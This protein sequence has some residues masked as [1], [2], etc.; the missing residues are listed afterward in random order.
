MNNSV[1]RIVDIPEEML[2]AI[3]RKL[4]NIDILYS[5][6]GV[7]QKLDKVA[8][9]INFTRTIDLTMSSSDEAE[10][11]GTNTILD[12]FCM[13]I[14]PRIYQNIEYL[15]IQGCFSQRV[16]HASIYPN[17]RKLTLINLEL[18]MA[19]RMFN[20]KSPFIQIFKRQISDLVVTINNKISNKPKKK[21]AIGVYFNIFGLIENL[22]YLDFN[23]NNNYPFPR[24]LLSSL[25]STTCFLPKIAHLCIKMHNFNDCRWLLD[26]RL[27]QLHTCIVDVDYI[28]KSS[29]IINNTNTRLKLKSF[30]LYVR[31]PTVE[32]DNQVVPLLRRMVR[33]ETLT[34]SLS[35]VRRASFLDGTYLA[36]SIINHMSRL[37]TFVFDIVTRGTM[38]NAEIQPSADDIRRTFAQIGIHVDCYME[39]DS[40]GISR[41]HVYSLPFTMTHI[42]IIT[43][44]FPGGMFINVRV[45]RIIDFVHSFDQAFFARI[46]HAFPLLSHLSLTITAELKEKPSRQLKNVEE[47]RSIVEYPRL[48]ELT[49]F[50]AHID[51]VEQFLCN[52]YTHLPCL[53]KLFVEYQHLNIVTENFTRNAT[54]MN[55]AKL[56]YITF[57][58][59]IKMVHSKN[60]SLYFP[61]L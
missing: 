16:L 53:S 27:C 41:C 8:C 57:D 22:K 20:G 45:L 15:I 17:L 51:Y 3:F 28:R 2:L 39:Y 24:P 4:N 12:R 44:N 38:T 54:R 58:P 25:S 61:S 30:S 46:S 60:F 29:M 33:M 13:H 42:H 32:F 10:Y 47:T 35:V 56:K 23:V 40:H 14:L 21:L 49:F 55:C 52:L 5:L 6:V 34:L 36:D 31:H 37:H 26:G 59:E 50:G 11:S 18:K 7:N 19:S 1:I 48:S 43:Y 9:D